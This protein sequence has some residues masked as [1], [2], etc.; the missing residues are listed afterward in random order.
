MSIASRIESIEEHIGN[1][2]DSIEALGVDITG[3]NK[4]IENIS[5]VLD[6]I[7]DSMPQVSG[8]GTSITLDNTRVGKIKSTLKGNT[9]QNGTP[10]PNTP[11]PVNVVSGDNSLSICGKNRL[12]NTNFSI[13]TS[14]VDMPH[15]TLTTI[16]TGIRFT[17]TYGNGAPVVYINTGIDLSNYTG[18]VVRMKCN[19]TTGGAFR[20]YTGGNNNSNLTLKAYSSNSGQTLSYT[21]ENNLGENK[22]L[23]FGLVCSVS[24]AKSV[25]FTDLIITIDNEDM[26]YEPYTGATYP[27]N[28]PEGMELCKIGDYQDYFL[29]DKTLDKWYKV[30]MVG[31]LVLDENSDL[32]SATSNTFRVPNNLTTN[33]VRPLNSASLLAILSNYLRPLSWDSNWNNQTGFISMLHTG[34]TDTR[35]KIY[36]TETLAE[37][38]TW[39]STHNIEIY[40]ECI[41]PTTTEITYQ[42]LIEQLNNLEK[43]MSYNSQ[44]NISQVNNDLPFIISASALKEWSE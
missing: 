8:E 39:L 13:V 27:I 11:I 9:S 19:Y 21:I 23:I 16:N 34:E 40:Y 30:G 38:N 5:S 31:K 18:K 24:Q 25:D 35:I 2:Y 6:T 1:A 32:R 36:G 29:H 41:T 7:Y 10:T 42:P 14:N 26:T 22:Y 15:N 12:D 3:V 17:T 44:T 33:I 37:L 28:L 20:F 4:N 43:A